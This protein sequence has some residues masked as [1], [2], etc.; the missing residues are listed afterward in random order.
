MDV[1][2]DGR[3][4]DVHE[5]EARER[6]GRS[7]VVAGGVVVRLVSLV[8]QLFLHV[9]VYQVQVVDVVYLDLR[10]HCCSIT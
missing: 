8:V 4:L 3:G 7:C 9:R 2:G 6:V 1:A 10:G 5:V